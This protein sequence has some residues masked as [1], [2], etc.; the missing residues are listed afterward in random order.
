VFAKA[1]GAA[2]PLGWVLDYRV[3][4]ARGSRDAAFPVPYSGFAARG[5][6]LMETL[7]GVL[8]AGRTYLFRLRAPGA[9]EVILVSGAKRTM[10]TR[11]GEEFSGEVSAPAGETVMY[12]KY[13]GGGE[14]QGLLRY[15][16][17]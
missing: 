6:W 15:V 3:S 7:S 5:A 10:L 16:G 9:L 11:S 1:R 4:A 14:Y 8:D 2:G 13:A 17:R 12:A